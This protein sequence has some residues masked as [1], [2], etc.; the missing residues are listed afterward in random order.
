[1]FCAN[2][3]P[4]T[5][6]LTQRIRSMAVWLHW[7][8]ARREP[9]IP[10]KKIASRPTLMFTIVYVIFYER[11]YFIFYECRCR[12]KFFVVCRSIFWYFLWNVSYFRK[13]LTGPSGMLIHTCWTRVFL[14]IFFRYRQSIGRPISGYL[15]IRKL[16]L[17]FF[18]VL[19][20][21]HSLTLSIV[22]IFKLLSRMI[23]CKGSYIYIYI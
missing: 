4:Q 8:D 18:V 15:Q 9:F 11:S 16:Y 22:N 20:L 17:T 23:G 14:V 7:A 12:C 1:M 19:N 10:N 21:I 6:V 13:I 3:L 2:F 5:A